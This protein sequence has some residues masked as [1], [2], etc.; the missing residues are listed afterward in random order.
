MPTPLLSLRKFDVA[1]KRQ[2]LLDE[3]A[4]LDTI[5]P[6]PEPV[7]QGSVIRFRKYDQ[8]YSFA[9]IKIDY[10]WYVTQDGSRSARQGRPPMLWSELLDWIGERNYSTVEVLS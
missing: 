4:L 9:A 1:L 2:K 10:H 7:E 8:K 5:T 3:L 6:L